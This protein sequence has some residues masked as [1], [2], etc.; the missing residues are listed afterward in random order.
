MIWWGRK[1]KESYSE[2]KYFTLLMTRIFPKTVPLPMG[3]WKIEYNNRKVDSK[4]DLSN[5]DHCGPCGQYALTKQ[6]KK[7]ESKEP[8]THK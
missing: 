2:M 7:M 3:R 5:E 4:I 8:T 6:S 1:E